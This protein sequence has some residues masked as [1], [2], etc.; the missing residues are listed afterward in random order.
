[1]TE[2]QKDIIDAVAEMVY[3]DLQTQYK[4]GDQ[5]DP[6]VL[7]SRANGAIST[8]EITAFTAP[9]VLLE[10]QRSSFLKK[11]THGAYIMQ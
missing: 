6:S 7:L 11:D 8:L 10:M 1:M 9:K 5:L 3:T 4:R 2:S